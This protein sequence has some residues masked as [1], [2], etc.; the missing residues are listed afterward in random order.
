MKQHYKVVIL[1]GGSGGIA[2]A[3]RLAKKVSL[4]NKIL[5]IDHADYHAFQ[6]SWPLVGSGA[7]KKEHTRK[8]MRRVVPHGAEFMQHK[9]SR[10]QPIE[11]LVTL[12]HGQT[13]SYDFLVV[14]LGIQLDFDQIEGLTETLGKNNVCTNYLYDYVDY[15]YDTLRHVTAGNVIA[16]KPNSPI[17]GGVAPENS[18][19]TFHDFF[20]KQGVRDVKLMLR[21]GNHTLFPVEKYRDTL[22]ELFTQKQIDYTL[23]D[24]LVKV[25]G[26]RQTATFF[27]YQ[28]R[29]TTEVPFSML[30]VTPPM[31]APDIIKE[32]TLADE[33]GWLDVN[34]FTLQHVRHQ[35]IFGIGDCTNLPTVKMG[36]AVRKQAHILPKN[37]ISQMKGRKLKA[38][39]T[40]MTACPIATEYGEA[41]MAEFDYSLKPKETLPFNQARNSKFLY[42]FK[43]RLLP[44]MYWYGML[45]GR[46]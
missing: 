38:H 5:I 7:E 44:I 21:S 46:S 33:A 45:K 24:E 6:P 27:N 11:R 41:I 3:S 2:V 32:S 29:T 31:S 10:I 26:P 13:V 35:N 30:L 16:T 37:L 28:N 4:K 34:P 12:D 1:G 23:N 8:K 15:T 9:V 20:H 42:L 39:Y 22:I 14:A 40:G 18:L 43:K 17:K 36:A 25:D 19:F